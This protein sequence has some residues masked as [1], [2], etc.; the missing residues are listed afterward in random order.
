M[1]NAEIVMDDVQLA[2]GLLD[3]TKNSHGKLSHA[4]IVFGLRN[5][6]KLKY[7]PVAVKFFFSG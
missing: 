2:K 5:L 3:N 6:L 4:E 7:Y 1:I